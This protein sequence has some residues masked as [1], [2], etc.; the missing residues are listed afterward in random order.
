MAVG[1]NDAGGK[2]GGN[3]EENGEAEDSDAKMAVAHSLVDGAVR[4]LAANLNLNEDDIGTPG[5][6][7]ARTAPAVSG[8]P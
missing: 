2:V 3:G 4:Q 1:A 5:R 8:P 7:Q 6:A